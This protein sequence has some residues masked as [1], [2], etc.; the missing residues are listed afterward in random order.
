VQLDVIGRQFLPDEKGVEHEVCARAQRDTDAFAVETG[1]CRNALVFS[2]DDA[3][4]FLHR[5]NCCDDRHWPPVRHREHDGKVGRGSEVGSSFQGRIQHGLPGCV[6]LQRD[7]QTLV[8]E[9]SL[10]LRDE[11]RARS[12]IMGVCG[13]CHGFGQA[14]GRLR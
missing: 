14:G 9:I 12:R 13:N 1:Y 8:R 5:K 10:H 4:I 3:V 6:R 2:T 7:A 11:Y